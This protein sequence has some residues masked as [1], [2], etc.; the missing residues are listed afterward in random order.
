MATTFNTMVTSSL[1][2]DQS[3][4]SDG[5]AF[6]FIVWEDTRSATRMLSLVSMIRRIHH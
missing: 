5:L 4:A 1:D 2:Q 6:L 3:D